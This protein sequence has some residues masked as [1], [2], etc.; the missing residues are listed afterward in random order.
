[1]KTQQRYFPA[2]LLIL[3]ILLQYHVSR[4]QPLSDS[5]APEFDYIQ[6]VGD[7]QFVFVML[8]IEDDPSAYGQG[9]AVQD[10]NIRQQYSQS[11][12]YENDVSTT[13]LWTV[14]WYAFQ[15]E[16]S[17]DGKYL[18][19]WGPWPFHEDYDELALAFYKDGVEIKR[20]TVNDLV[21]DPKSLPRS[22]SH[23]FWVKETSFNPTTNVL[24]LETQNGEVYDFDV[25][26][27]EKSTESE[28]LP[29][30]IVRVVIIGI[31]IFGGTF[32][33][34]KRFRNNNGIPNKPA[35]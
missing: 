28:L 26:T 16:I 25:T 6:E 32:L 34:L 33:L 29:S 10:Q 21:A 19:R 17:S 35:A 7:G 9:G 5:P 20:Y 22:V 30:N 8:S 1:M 3:A 12:L 4:A 18:V 27:E 24:H 14:D 13:P 31:L 23:Y 11:G 2:L 15:V